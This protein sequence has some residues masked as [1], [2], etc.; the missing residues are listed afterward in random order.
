MH[1]EGETLHFM[2]ALCGGRNDIALEALK[3]RWLVFDRNGALFR[4]S[5]ELQLSIQYMRCP[6]LREDVARQVSLLIL[7]KS[8]G[9]FS[10]WVDVNTVPGRPYDVLLFLES[11]GRWGRN[12]DFERQ[13]QTAPRP[14]LANW[15]IFE[16]VA[17]PPPGRGLLHAW[18]T[19]WW[20]NYECRCKSNVPSPLVLAYFFY[21]TCAETAFHEAIWK[22]AVCEFSVLL[23][24]TFLNCTRDGL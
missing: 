13:M 9:D 4:K 3:K 8:V 17:A 11:L 21:Q 18:M 5:G 23:L 12:C 15:H 14:V 10:N 6:E 2:D 7:Q 24:A 16:M 20:S 22:V 19:Q 1:Q